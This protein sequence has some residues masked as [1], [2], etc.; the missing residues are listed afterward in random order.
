MAK[1][2]VKGGQSLMEGKSVVAPWPMY[3]DTDRQ[4]L[5]RALESRI[6]CCTSH[7][8]QADSEVGKFE[9]AF[10]RYQDAKHGCAVTNGTTAIEV[11]L[12][13]GGVEL[14]DEVIVPASSFIATAMAVSQVGAVPVFADIDPKTLTMDVEDARRKITPQTKA[15]LPVDFYGQPAAIPELMALAEEHDI[16]ALLDRAGQDPALRW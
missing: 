15:I 10:A 7:R 8:K 3:D 11:A 16:L 1:L 5:N 13:A 9:I 2:A 14:G 6:W 4:A 12:K